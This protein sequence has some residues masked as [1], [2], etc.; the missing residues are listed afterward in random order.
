MRSVFLAGRTTYLRALELDDLEH[1]WRWF[2]DREIVRYSLGG[3]L[4]PTS[5]WETQ[6][7]LEQT[8]ADKRALSLGIVEQATDRL[9]GY[10]GITSISQIN[11]SGEYF[12]LIGDKQCWGKGYG[13]EVTRLI[14]HYG[15]V[16]L[17]LHRIMLTV[18]S[19]NVGAVK[20]YTR[21]GFEVEGCM[22]DACYRD[23]AYHDKLIMAILRPNWADDAIVDAS[24]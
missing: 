4:F 15:F 2:A 21:A 22:R 11:R 10:G 3:W 1:F 5:R 16:T 9:I 7:W 20:A 18:S 19:P 13:T 24:H 6:Q 17:N 8:L 14:V 23:G 12:L